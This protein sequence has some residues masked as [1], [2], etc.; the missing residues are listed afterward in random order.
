MHRLLNI[1]CAN[2]LQDILYSELEVIGARELRRHSHG[3][4]CRA[5]L[6]TIYRLCLWSRLASRVLLQIARFPVDSGDALYTGAS[7]VDWST[8]LTSETS[9]A[10][11]FSGTGAGIDNSHYAALRVKDAIVDHFRRRQGQRPSIDTRTP[12]IRVHGR[13]I[14][15]QV[16]LSLDLSGGSLHQRGYRKATGAAPLKENL[17]AAILMRAGWPDPGFAALVDPLCGSATL[18]IEGAMMAADIAPGLQRRSFGFEHWLEHDPCLWAAAV[19]EAKAR[20]QRGLAGKLP[21]VRGYDRSTNVISSAHSNIEAAGLAGYIEVDRVPLEEICAIETARQDRGLLVTNPPYGA[22]MG[23]Q[24]ELEQLYAQ[25]GQVLKNQFAGWKAAVFSANEALCFY[26]G[27]R[28]HKQYRLYN[29]RLPAKLLLFEIF[30]E[31]REEARDATRGETRHPGQEMPRSDDIQ[32]LQEVPRAKKGAGES[33]GVSPDSKQSPD[34]Q[35]REP[36]Q[37]SSGAEMLANRL[38]KNR[39]KLARWLRDQD[40]TC[41]RLYDADLPEYAV[42]I[43]CYEG[44]VLVQEYAPPATVDAALAEQRLGEVQKVIRCTLAPG[45]EHI[46]FRQ[47]RR[48]RGSQQYQRSPSGRGEGIYR[49]FEGGLCFEV[50]LRDYLDSGLFLDHRPVRQLIKSLS[51]GKRF[52]NLFCYTATATVYAAAGGALSSLSVDMSNTYLQWAA[53]NFELNNVN[54]AQH[55]LANADCLKWLAGSKDD[56]LYDVILLDPPTFSNSKKMA[57]ILDIQKDHAELIAN[58]MR[59]LAGGGTLIFSTNARRFKL[60]AALFERYRVEDISTRSIDRDFQRRAGIHS[61]WLIQHR[62]AAPA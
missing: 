40:I 10:V 43:D 18:L 6:P 3:V 23:R 62:S 35:Q 50:N 29:G 31:T 47:R 24:D 16:V 15:G 44:A 9:F 30:G 60:D 32:E 28:A 56:E 39:K 46:Y 14:R 11:D 2:G 36:E 5:D 20:R 38:K 42:A 58:A 1:S 17:A 26:L 48:Q 52:L 57:G 27:L 61:A 37:L 49:V 41:Y 45:D 21:S 25:L 4:H 55:R 51:N 19:E 8:L 34:T 59:R 13:L 53:R 33:P 22:R 7:S 54:P 12:D